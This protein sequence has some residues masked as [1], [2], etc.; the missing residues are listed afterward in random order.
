[1]EWEQFHRDAIPT[2]LV[3]Y[4]WRRVI[5][6]QLAL[7][8]FRKLK[9]GNSLDLFARSPLPRGG[10]LAASPRLPSPRHVSRARLACIPRRA[11][12]RVPLHLHG[13]AWHRLAAWRPSV[14][15]SLAAWRVSL[16]LARLSRR[17]AAHVSAW[18]RTLT[19]SASLLL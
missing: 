7:F 17:V 11:S 5:P 12:R 1:M 8:H 15:A 6:P 10:T 9:S 3:G 19:A 16:A 2:F 4:F 13:G 14:A 18:R